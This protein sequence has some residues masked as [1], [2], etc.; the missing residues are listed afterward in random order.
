[1]PD[2]KKEPG[3]RPD[4]GPAEMPPGGD[5][6][7]DDPG[8]IEIGI[9]MKSDVRVTGLLAGYDPHDGDEQDDAPR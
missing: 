4:P 3:E 6:A 2:E 1:M 9:V 8:P 5:V 7:A